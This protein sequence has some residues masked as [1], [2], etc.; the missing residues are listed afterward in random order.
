[1]CLTGLSPEQILDT[2]VDFV[3][4]RGLD[5]FPLWNRFHIKQH[6]IIFG[7]KRQLQVFVSDGY[8]EG[9][10]TWDFDKPGNI[11]VV[12]LVGARKHVNFMRKRWRAEYPNHSISFNR[13]ETV[14]H[15]KPLTEK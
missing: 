9:L 10:C 1:M 2:L 5:A 6:L 11:H 7:A 14:K 12:S 13:G 8:L 15:F 4:A 3:C